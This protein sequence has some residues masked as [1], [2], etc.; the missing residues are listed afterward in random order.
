[1]LV[2]FLAATKVLASKASTSTDWPACFAGL[3]ALLAR[4]PCWPACLAGPPAL[5]A[6]LPCW[7]ACLAGPPALLARLPCW[8]AC[9]AGLSTLLACL[10]CWPGC[11]VGP[12]A[13]FA[14]LIFVTATSALKLK[15]NFYQLICLEQSIYLDIYASVKVFRIS[16]QNVIK[17]C[18]KDLNDLSLK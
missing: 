14:C 13:L 1:M 7:P 18:K 3:P 2:M 4:L 9:L 6:R 12:P 11:L 10:P 8:P 15:W 16:A 5:L 17:H